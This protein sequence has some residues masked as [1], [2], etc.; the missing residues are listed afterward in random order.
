MFQLYHDVVKKATALI[1]HHHSPPLPPHPHTLYSELIHTRYVL[2]PAGSNLRFFFI[3]TTPFIAP[4]S[5]YS[6]AE[7][8]PVAS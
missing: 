8:S 6:G 5:K 2:R 7:L 3:V 4:T 1:T